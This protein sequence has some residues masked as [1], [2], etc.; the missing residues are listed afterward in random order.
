VRALVLGATGR[1]GNAVV[2]ELLG[3]GA[4]VTATSRRALPP[5]NFADLPVDYRSGDL[6]R[7]GQ[8]EA[9]IRDHDVV[10]DAAAPYPLWLLEEAPVAARLAAAE[11]RVDTLLQ[12]VAEHRTHLVFLSSFVAGRSERPL[13]DRAQSRLLRVLHPYFEL[14]RR[15]DARVREAMRAGLSIVLFR[16]TFCIGP[17]DIGDPDVAF[18]PLL[19]NGKLPAL[20]A[21]AMNAIDVR[22]VAALVG[23]A[24]ERRTSGRSISAVGHDTTVEILADLVCRTAGVPKPRW[25]VAPAV[26]AAA[27]YANELAYSSGL[28]ESAHPAVGTLLLLEQ[29]WARPSAEQRELGVALRPLSRTVVDALD[30]YGRRGA[31]SR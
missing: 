22:D 7:P 27:A 5:E 24:L 20:S 29:A 12:S 30:W 21:H 31:F 28:S 11:R 25:R 26:A 9:W 16:P 13:L 1:I 3:R 23:A 14:K 6:D 15:L 8:L 18:I 2:R 19:V 4:K 10:V 17:W